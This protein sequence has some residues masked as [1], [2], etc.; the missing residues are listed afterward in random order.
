VRYAFWTSI[1]S[2]ATM[3]HTYGGQGIWNW[4]RPGDDETPLAGPQFGPTWEE[5]L[6]HPGAAQ[7][8]LGAR[9]LRSLPWWRLRP[10]PWRV[11][12][13]PTADGRAPSCAL[14]P[15]ETWIAYLPDAGGGTQL[16]GAEPGAW[17]ARW[18][19]PR[20]GASCP[21]DPVASDPTGVL[22]LP[23]APGDGDWVA[24][25]TPADESAGA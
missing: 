2:G 21:I 23:S 19:D 13:E 6:R 10:E 22:S 7:C 5:A 15:G 8:A 18:F 20:T 11:R 12:R 1:L 25:L 16:L 9:L 3:G 4:K 24:V 14:A 17:Q